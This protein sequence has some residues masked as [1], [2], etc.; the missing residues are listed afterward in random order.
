M[1]TVLGEAIRSRRAARSLPE[2]GRE[3]GVSHQ[4]VM[5]LEHGT[6]RPS[7]DTAR[8]LATWLGWSTDQVMDA[9]SEPVPQTSDVES[10]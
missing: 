6:H 4:T 1:S 7:F 10:R 8:K 3:L 5:R 9:A 2:V